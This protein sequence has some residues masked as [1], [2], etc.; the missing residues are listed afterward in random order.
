MDHRKISETFFSNSIRAETIIHLAAMCMD[1]S[2]P[3]EVQDAFQDDWERIWPALGLDEPDTEDREEI[4]SRLFLKKRLGF[5]VKVATPIPRNFSK[6]SSAYQFSWGIY[7]TEWIYDDSLEAVYE[8]AAAWQERL[9]EE[10]R[11]AAAA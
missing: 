4:A 3:S 7:A 8:K 1:D 10:K 11:K 2:W 5:L 9:I 6:D